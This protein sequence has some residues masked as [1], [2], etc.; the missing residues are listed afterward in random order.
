MQKTDSADPE[1][2][3][4]RLERLIKFFEKHNWIIQD[5]DE[6]KFKDSNKDRKRITE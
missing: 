4:V 3:I 5:Y 1:E 6:E 2:M